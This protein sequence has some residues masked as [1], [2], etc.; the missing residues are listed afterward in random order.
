[1]F[2]N[3]ALSDDPESAS[4][5]HCM[6]LQISTSNSIIVFESIRINKDVFTTLKAA[7]QILK[8]ERTVVTSY[9]K[10]GYLVVGIYVFGWG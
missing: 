9:S 8:S 10:L 5:K 2:R 1:M 6:S 7:L 3:S 4:T